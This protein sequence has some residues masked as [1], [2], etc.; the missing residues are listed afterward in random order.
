MIELPGYRLDRELHA[1]VHSRV[2]KATRERD[3]KPVILKIAVPTQAAVGKLLHEHEVAGSLQ[4]DGIARMLGL[5][6]RGDLAVL[7]VE[8]FGARSLREMCSAQRLDLESALRIAIQIVNAIGEIHRAGVIHMDINP[9][10]VIVHEDTGQ[11]KICDFGIASV[12]RREHWGGS[13]SGTFQGTLSY[14]SPEQ[15]GRMNRT[16]D[17][18]T[19][20]Y[21]FGVTLYELLIGWP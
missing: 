3:G 4:A 11:V 14:I 2:C 16:I 5:E 7:L 6:R 19:D 17:Y 18:R 21:S 9:S 20:F 12:L 13:S 15:T 10:N 8:D 1:G